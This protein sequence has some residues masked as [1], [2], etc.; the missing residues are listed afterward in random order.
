MADSTLTIGTT[1]VQIL[2]ANPGRQSA[3]IQNTHASN[4]LYLR[5]RDPAVSGVGIRLA[6]G[7]TYEINATNPWYGGIWGI[8]NAAGCTVQADEV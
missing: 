3:D 8:S 4:Y 5:K 6:P 1:S 7:G 2:F